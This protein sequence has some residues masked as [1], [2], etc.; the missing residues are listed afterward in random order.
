[1]QK[2]VFLQ[3]NFGNKI[4]FVYFNYIVSILPFNVFTSFNMTLIFLVTLSLGVGDAYGVLSDA[5]AAQ[6]VISNGGKDFFLPRNVEV[7]VLLQ[8]MLQFLWAIVEMV[9]FKLVV[10]QPMH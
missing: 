4:N 1:M 2:I 10:I 7:S 5:I 8:Y 3:E 9:V 6:R